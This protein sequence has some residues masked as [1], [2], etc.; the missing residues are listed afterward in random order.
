MFSQIIEKVDNRRFLHLLASVVSVCL[1][2]QGRVL[3]PAFP[4]ISINAAARQ[5]G[6]SIPFWCAS[7]SVFVSIYFVQSSAL[8]VCQQLRALLKHSI[9]D[10]HERGNFTQERGFFTQGGSHA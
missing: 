1:V 5:F 8:R 9:G 3:F 10:T 4:S 2:R 6:S 7:A